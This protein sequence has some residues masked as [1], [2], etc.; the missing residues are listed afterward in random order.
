MNNHLDLII[1]VNEGFIIGYAEFFFYC[2]TQRVV[3]SGQDNSISPARVVN[4]TAGF[5]PAC[6]LTGLDIQ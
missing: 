4:R 5:G 2:E 1:L 6:N 3:T